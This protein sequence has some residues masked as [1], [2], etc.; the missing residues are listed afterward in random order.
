VIT[1]TGASLG[2]ATM[3]LEGGSLDTRRARA[4]AGRRYANGLDVAF[5]GTYERSGGVERLYY[6][7]FDTPGTNNGVAA[8]LDGEQLGQFYSHIAF[9]DLT[10]TGAYGTRQRNVPTASFNTL[11]NAQ[12][13]S[14]QATDRHML[15]HAEYTRSIGATHVVARVAYDGFSADGTFPFAGAETEATPLVGQTNALGTRWTAGTWLTRALPGRQVLTFGAE[16]IDNLHQDQSGWYSDPG[17]PGYVENG[18]STQR[19]LFAQDEL[20][21]AGWLIL[22]AGLRYDDYQEFRRLTPRLAVIVMPSHH[23]S[24]KYLFGSAFRAPNAY[25]LNSFNFGV[26]NLRPESIDTHELVWESYTNDWLRTSVSMYSYEADRL[27]TLTPDPSTLFGVTYVNEGHAHARGLEIEAQMRVRGGV[28]GLMSYT[29]QQVKDDGNTPLTNSP[30]HMLKARASVAGPTARSFISLEALYLSSRKTLAGRLPPRAL[31]TV[32]MT[33]P[34]GRSFE[35]V[36][37]VRN[38]LDARYADPASEQHRQ[39]SIPQNGRTIRIGLQWK[40]S[41][42]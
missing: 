18:S 29:L 17:I 35:L 36:G 9:K 19:A 27:I 33:Q 4:T 7:A 22:N 5:S 8:G 15:L 2:G 28:Q 25:E 32:T 10:F 3:A 24:F 20:K 12:T 13:S 11:F 39:D 1:K 34:I 31:A 23:Q 26:T 21:V 14:E 42:K 41:L 30:L 40:L 38:L 16:F 6:P 37:S